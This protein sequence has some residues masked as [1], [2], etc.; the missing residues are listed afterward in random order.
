MVPPRL[1][2]SGKPGRQDRRHVD[3]RAGPLQDGLGL[4]PLLDDQAQDAEL[5]G[6]GQ[7]EGLDVDAG[8]GQQPAR[9]AQ[10]A[11]FVLKKNG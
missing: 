1:A 9:G 10:G 11:G 8:V 3:H 7:R 6:V 4:L 5:L 2:L